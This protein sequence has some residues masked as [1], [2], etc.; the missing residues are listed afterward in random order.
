M[1]TE[2]PNLPVAFACCGVPM[3]VAYTRNLSSEQIRRGRK[4]MKCGR[5]V[6]TLERPVER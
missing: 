6:V 4:C 2:K 1:A 5:K 3:E